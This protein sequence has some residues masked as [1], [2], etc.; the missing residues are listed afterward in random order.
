MG[1]LLKEADPVAGG[2]KLNYIMEGSPRY[3]VG[4]TL[5]YKSFSVLTLTL[6]IYMCGDDLRFKNSVAIT[7][8]AYGFLDCMFFLTL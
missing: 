4:G 1:I 3:E 8:S 2:Y 6:L 5:A 7:D